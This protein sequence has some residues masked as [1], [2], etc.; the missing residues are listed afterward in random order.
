MKIDFH[1]EDICVD[2]QIINKKFH[3]TEEKVFYDSYKELKKD[4]K[5]LCKCVII[6]IRFLNVF[7]NK[8]YIT[9][10]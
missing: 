3:F 7:V 2:F 6:K 10:I 5:W 8:I 9:I 4:L 1:I